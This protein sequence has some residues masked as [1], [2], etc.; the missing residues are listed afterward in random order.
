MENKTLVR[1]QEGQY[2]FKEISDVK[3][4][5]CDSRDGYVLLFAD[6]SRCICCEKCYESKAWENK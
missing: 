1:G 5:F 4:D 3:C 6:K 2:A